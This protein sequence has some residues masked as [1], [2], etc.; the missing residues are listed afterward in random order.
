MPVRRSDD[1]R[2]DTNGD[3]SPESFPSGHQSRL[4]IPRDWRST[5]N[6]KK[7]ENA[8]GSANGSCRTDQRQTQQLDMDME[9]YAD[10]PDSAASKAEKV[11]IFRACGALFSYPGAS[12]V[13][14]AA[15]SQIRLF[16][17]VVWLVVLGCWSSDVG[18]AISKPNALKQIPTTAV[19]LS[20]MHQQAEEAYST[21]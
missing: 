13:E 2:A 17:A 6:R 4:A 12:H 8:G 5:I 14:K 1:Q 16:F 15:Q 7:S 18:P 9:W 3:S 19:I 11:R 10:A 21:S 20:A